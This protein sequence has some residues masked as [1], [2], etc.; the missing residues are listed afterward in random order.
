MLSRKRKGVNWVL[1]RQLVDG[2]RTL[3]LKEAFLLGTLAMLAP[4]A[5]IYF[6]LKRLV[7]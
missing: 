3:S 4:F 2:M 1:V 6:L 5:P 7:R